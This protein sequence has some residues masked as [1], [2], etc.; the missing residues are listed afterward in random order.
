MKKATREMLRIASSVRVA[1]KPVTKLE[2]L[3]ENCTGSTAD[4]RTEP[5]PQE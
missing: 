4:H 1:A 3:K 2:V 5:T